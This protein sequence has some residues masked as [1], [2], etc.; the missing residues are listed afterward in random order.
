M[1]AEGHRPDHP[2][3]CFG[4]ARP[5]LSEGGSEKRSEE[6][7]FAFSTGQEATARHLRL[8]SRLQKRAIAVAHGSAIQTLPLSLRPHA[9]R[10]SLALYS[11]RP[12][13]S[14]SKHAHATVRK[15]KI[16]STKGHGG[17]VRTSQP[18]RT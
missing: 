8:S 13:M 6:A 4:Q 15:R 1:Q 12:F 16:R 2:S 11:D 5:N 7:R 17:A 9:V 10:A 18:K 3:P 14:A